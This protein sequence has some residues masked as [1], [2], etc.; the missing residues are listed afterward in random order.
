MLFMSRSYTDPSWDIFS[1]GKGETATCSAHGVKQG[2]DMAI[3]EL[4]VTDVHVLSRFP[5][6]AH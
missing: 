3:K 6:S 4:L 1:E 2:G 5:S